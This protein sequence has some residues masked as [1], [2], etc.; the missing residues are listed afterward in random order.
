MNSVALVLLFHAFVVLLDVELINVLLVPAPQHNFYHQR[1]PIEVEQPAAN[2]Q[3]KSLTIS[4]KKAGRV[5][6]THT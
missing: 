5:R 3:D 6:N 1:E 2:A 4:G